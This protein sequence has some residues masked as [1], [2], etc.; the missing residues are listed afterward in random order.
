MPNDIYARIKAF[1]ITPRVVEITWTPSKAGEWVYA[2]QNKK[3]SYTATVNNKAKNTD[4]VSINYTLTKD[5]EFIDYFE[6]CDA[7]T[8]KWTASSLSGAASSNYTLEGASETTK[9]QSIKCRL[10]DDF[11][12]DTLE[13]TYNGSV[14]Q[15]VASVRSGII[16]PDTVNVTSYDIKLKTG[17][18]VT[19]PVDAGVYQIKPLASV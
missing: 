16:L 6:I 2:G 5:G 10:L 3:Y 15:P 14:H 13:Y 12:W 9:T 18:T 7:A 8:Y 4:E 17:G 19:T 1:S 11:L